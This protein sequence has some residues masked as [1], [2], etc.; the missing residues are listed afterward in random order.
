MKLRTRLV[1]SNLL[2]L[3]I[4]VT[5]SLAVFYG[6]L[7]V[8]AIVTGLRDRQREGRSVM[9]V[10]ESAIRSM[11]EWSERG[12]ALGEMASEAGDFNSRNADRGMALLIY[13]NGRA[14]NE[15]PSFRDEDI[16]NLALTR[17]DRVMYL[18]RTA[19]W[20]RTINGYRV[21]LLENL[22]IAEI[23]GGYRDAMF[24]GT[25]LSLVCAAVMMILMNRL[26]T[27]FVFGKILRAMDT[28][29]GGAHEIRDGNLDFRI[30]YPYGDEF[31][32]VC[33]DFDEMA[34]R[35]QTAA[36]ARLKDEMSRRELFAGISHDLR[37]PLTSIKAYVE[38][39]EKGVASTPEARARYIGTIR[40]KADDL[41]HIIEALFLFSKLDT[42]EFPYSMERADLSAVVADITGEAAAEYAARGLE[43]TARA[44]ET[45]AWVN[46]DVSQL[47]RVMTNIFENSL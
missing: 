1:L 40:S 22:R 33:G 23:T 16:L 21:V 47:R 20:A 41:E 25:V 44:E 24:K 11:D 43:I 8:F 28:L 34:E 31:A 5:V 13:E 18:G 2:M 15:P 38:G 12:A 10:V 7:R 6:G 39:L 46:I 9:D 30:D 17:D 4:P 3:V 14:I 32:P 37:T 45:P 36:Q 29:S 27:Q 35:L 26:L 19:A 42:G